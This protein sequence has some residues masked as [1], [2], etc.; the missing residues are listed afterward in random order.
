MRVDKLRTILLFF[1]LIVFII[2]LTIAGTVLAS[3]SELTEVE[4]QQLKILQLSKIVESH[5]S[6]IDLEKDLENYQTGLKLYHQGDYQQAISQLLNIKYSTLNLPLYIKSQYI[7][8]ECLKKIEDWNVAIEVYKNLVKND[9]LITDYSL[10][11]L[12]DIYHLKGENHESINQF[13]KI[14]ENFPHSLIIS[15]VNYQIAQNYR[16]LNDIASAIIYYKDILKDSSDNQLKAKALLELAEI[17]WK[18][19]KYI[20]SLN[21]WYEILDKGYKLKR[22]SE[23]EELLIRHFYQL[24]DN[25]KEIDIPYLIMVKCADIL[26]KYRQYNLAEDLY[27]EIIKTFPEAK[28]IAEVYYKRARALYY[29]KDYKQVVDKCN[30]I[31]LRFPPSDIIIKAH[32]LFANSFLAL[33]ERYFAIDKY[34][35]II[36]QYPET[37][38]ARESYLRMSECYF[39]LGESEKGIFHWRQLIARYPNSDQAMTSWW[40]LARYYTE[41]NK[42][43]EALEAYRELSERFP[44]SRLGDDALYWRGKTLQKIGSEEEANSIYEKLLKDYPLSYYAERIIEQRGDIDYLWPVVSVSTK[45]DFTDLE[46]F[47]EKYGKINEK[48]QLFLLKAEL[49]KGI[50]FYKEAIIELKGGLNYNPGNIFLLF[51]LSDFY[52]KNEDYYD[53]LN[54][55]E[56]IFN[57]L[58]DNYPL[59]ELPLELWEQLY[60]TYFEDMIRTYALKYEIDFL[61]A[62]AMIREESRFNSWN[63]SVAGARGLMQIIFSTGEWIAQK[64]NIENFSDEMLFSPEVNINLGCWYIGYLKRKFSNDTILIISG[65][66]AGPGI[67][68]KWVERYDRSDLDNFVENIPYSETREHIKKVMKSYQMYKRLI[69]IKE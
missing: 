57:Y 48:G 53:S 26:F 5:P 55:T 31:I 6:N 7:L 23:P 60:P 46:G 34:K 17:Y 30:E 21:C 29:K 47:L 27:G 67:T 61:L 9:P 50:N 43:P 10:F 25:M 41:N 38:Y 69:K 52:L 3:S 51:R 36:E 65:Y 49:F 39:Q 28:D 16:E 13:K 37:Y 64:L 45:K 63:E 20:D 22:N 66:N 33:G 44:K 35:E 19:E 59:E 4:A 1:L 40:N 15:E 11:Y 8:G 58:Q 56:I 12:A 54:Y 18:E 24:Q 32:Y 62:L 2:F 14:I 42:D 68:D